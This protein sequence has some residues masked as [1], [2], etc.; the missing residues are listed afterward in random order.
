M[1][2]FAVSS[3]S[4]TGLRPLGARTAAGTVMTKRIYC[5]TANISDTLIDNKVVYHSDVVG[6]SPAGATPTTSSFST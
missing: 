2:K 3:K 4:A 5:K 6:A 1:S